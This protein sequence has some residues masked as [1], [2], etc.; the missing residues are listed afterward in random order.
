LNGLPSPTSSLLS[1]SSKQGLLAAAGPSSLILART[2]A[3]RDAFTAEGN[4]VAENVKEFRPALEIS[5]PKLS[6]VAFTA[7]GTY[8]VIGAQEGGGLGV[9]ETQALLQDKKETTFQ[10][11][12]NNT[13]IRALA[14]NPAAEFA[15]L[16]A[17]ILTDGKLLIA[18]LRNRDFIKNASGSPA[19]K[20]GVAAVSWSNR[21]KQLTAGMADGNCFQLDQLGTVKASI[22]TPPDL[23]SHYHGKSC[24]SDY[25]RL[26]LMRPQCLLLYG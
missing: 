8:L 14:P 26:Y 2:K 23:P 10:L 21:G 1:I 24:C 13:S 11:P 7:D 20:E 15:H 16:V 6:Q 4:E 22:P 18:D 12:T 9:Y 3:V 5:V 25:V 17:V 19:L